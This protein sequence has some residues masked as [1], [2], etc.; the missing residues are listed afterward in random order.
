VILIRLA[1]LVQTLG[2]VC[3]GLIWIS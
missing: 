3:K 2:P 1:K